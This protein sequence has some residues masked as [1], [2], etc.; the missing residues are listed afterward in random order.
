M[1]QFII[2]ENE[3]GQRLDR[4]LFKYLNNT[5][6]TN[7]F[8]LIRK[9]IIRVNG[10]KQSEN[11]MLTEGDVIEIRLHENAV[12]EM[13]KEEVEEDAVLK[14]DLDIIFED[15]E[16]LVVNKPS[17]LLTHPDKNEY[18]RTLTTYVQHYL[19]SSWTKT[20]KPACI[21][22][23]DKNT[24]GI[25]I[26]GKTYQSLKKYN[27]LMRNR[28]IKKY[29]KCIVHG[30]IKEAGEIKGYL[31]KNMDKNIVRLQSYEDETFSKEVYTKYIPL[32]H[33]KG[34]TLLEVELLTGRSHQIRASLAYI[35][36]P[37][38]GDTKYDGK[39]IK[40]VTTQVLHAWRSCVGDR[41][42][43]SENH[44][45]EKLWEKL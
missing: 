3:S 29:Y 21:Q 22:R 19:K 42:F 33:K 14:H 38:I 20:F 4:F 26:F 2:T 37:I 11:F 1:H 8:K 25:V 36:H 30:N 10:K 16:I 9:K 12:L 24:S 17:G 40:G 31:S 34:Y 13:M 41:E 45:L 39:K 18:K 32:D 15:D 28:E 7:I 23:L 6:R 35:G 44:Q 5:P 43:K 27:E